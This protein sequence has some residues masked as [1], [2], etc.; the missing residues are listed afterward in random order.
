MTFT[1]PKTGI[2]AIKTEKP[3]LVSTIYQPTP[4]TTAPFDLRYKNN[5]IIPLILKISFHDINV[6][7][8]TENKMITK[9]HYPQNFKAQ[10]QKKSLILKGQT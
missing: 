9:I 8:S 4:K 7:L 5:N 2:K 6:S 3:I 1:A 10:K